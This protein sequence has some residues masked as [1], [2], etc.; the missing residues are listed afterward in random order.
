MAR[1]KKIGPP[2]M[3]IFLPPGVI[4]GGRRVGVIGWFCALACPPFLVRGARRHVLGVWCAVPG[5]MF[6]VRAALLVGLRGPRLSGQCSA[7]CPV[8]PDHGVML[9][10]AAEALLPGRAP[11]AAWREAWWREGG[12]AI[13]SRRSCC[14]GSAPLR[15][16]AGSRGGEKEAKFR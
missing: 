3:I 4:P 13:L 10:F 7:R 12:D 8:P 2:K 14:W 6:S 9:G 11:E 16:R 1:P 5:A 15:R